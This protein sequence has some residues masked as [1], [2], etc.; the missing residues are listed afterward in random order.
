MTRISKLD[1]ESDFFNF[2]IGNLDL[3]QNKFQPLKADLT[4]HFKLIVTKQAKDES[5]NFQTHTLNYTE[6]KRVYTKSIDFKTSLKP[7]L[8]IF[9]N[10]TTPCDYIFFLE[11]A[12]ESGKYSR[13]KCDSKFTQKQFESF[14]KTWIINSLNK[15]IADKVFY[16]K[17]DKKVVGFVSLKLNVSSAQIGLIAISSN[18]QGQGLGSILLNV[19]ENYCVQ[20]KVHRLNITTQKSNTQ[21]CAFYEKNGY[22]INQDIIIKHYWKTKS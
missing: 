2:N 15:K 4:Q 20:K 10:S 18:L 6:T 17:K 19:A 7:N 12:L 22:K 8:D 5:I 21:A 11:L 14:Y 3:L 1:W 16:I 13:F 9:D